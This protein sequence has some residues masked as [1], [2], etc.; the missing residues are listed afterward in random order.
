MSC[1]S[2]QARPALLL[3]SSQPTALCWYPVPHSTY[4]KCAETLVRPVLIA[5]NPAGFPRGLAVRY[6]SSL[7]PS[8]FLLA[9]GLYHEHLPGSKADG[10]QG[11]CQGLLG[12]ASGS[13]AWKVG[14]V[15]CSWLGCRI[16][17]S[18]HGSS[19]LHNHIS[20]HSIRGNEYSG[21]NSQS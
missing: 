8:L 9:S 10:A 19:D 13:Q 7:A 15:V 16:W 5:A 14:P 11:V 21:H 6:P 1:K 17:P 3:C 4:A 18:H 20:S 2:Y 12:G